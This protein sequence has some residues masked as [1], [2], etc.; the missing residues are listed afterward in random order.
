[1]LFAMTS[2]HTPLQ[3][4]DLGLVCLDDLRERINVLC[5]ITNQCVCSLV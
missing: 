3:P 1:M 5:E 2:K 4:N